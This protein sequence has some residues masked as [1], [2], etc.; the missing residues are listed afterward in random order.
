[1]CVAGVAMREGWAGLLLQFWW[2]DPE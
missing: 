1:V 2:W